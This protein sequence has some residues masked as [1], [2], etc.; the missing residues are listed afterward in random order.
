VTDLKGA[1]A[2]I[3]RALKKAGEHM[4]GFPEIEQALEKIKA[5]REAVPCFDAYF[6][7][8]KNDECLEPEDFEDLERAAMLLNTIT[9]EKD[10]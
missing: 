5:I 3:E 1:L 9:G 2:E 6:K 4:H 7:R 10:G 8:L